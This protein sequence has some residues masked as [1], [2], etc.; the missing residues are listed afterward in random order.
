MLQILTYIKYKNTLKAC[1]FYNNYIY[2]V[3]DK[4][5]YEKLI[6]IYE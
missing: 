4:C 2:F 1:K 5:L 6:R 3:F